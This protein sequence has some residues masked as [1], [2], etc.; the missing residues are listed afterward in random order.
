MDRAVDG[1]LV[2]AGGMARRVTAC[3]EFP[4]SPREFPCQFPCQFPS[5][6]ACEFP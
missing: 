1:E 3:A 5:E 4:R 6:F 2:V